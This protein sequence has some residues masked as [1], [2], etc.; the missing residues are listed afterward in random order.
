MYNDAR[1][2]RTKLSI[3]QLLRTL[4]AATIKNSRSDTT[5]ARLKRRRFNG[6]ILPAGRRRVSGHRR[7]A[8][9]TPLRRRAEVVAAVH[10]SAMQVSMTSTQAAYPWCEWDQ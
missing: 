6:D 10:A 8:F 5:A 7:P 9:R 3:V 4:N 1:V 2:E